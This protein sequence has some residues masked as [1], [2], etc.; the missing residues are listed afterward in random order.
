MTDPEKPRPRATEREGSQPIEWQSENN[1]ESV[2]EEQRDR[3]RNSE[4]DVERL[5]DSA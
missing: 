1:L 5:E 2:P 3:H 4:S